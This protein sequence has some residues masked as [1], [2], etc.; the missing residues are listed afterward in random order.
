MYLPGAYGI[1][2]FSLLA[3]GVVGREPSDPLTLGRKFLFVVALLSHSASS[4]SRA[5]DKLPRP[6][7][8]RFFPPRGNL[9]SRAAIAN[10]VP[11]REYMAC[12]G[13]AR[14]PASYRH[15]VQVY[16]GVRTF[17]LTTWAW[18][19]TVVQKSESPGSFPGRLEKTDE[20]PTSGLPRKLTVRGTVH[21]SHGH[22][23]LMGR[24]CHAP[25]P[26]FSRKKKMRS[27]ALAF[28]SHGPRHGPPETWVA[29]SLTA[30]ETAHP[31]TPSA[32]I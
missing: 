14:Y 13:S 11:F 27:P 1:C 20:G 3:A 26:L 15:L 16:L 24:V 21:A 23:G 25:R 10:L 6:A 12:L 30:V 17:C 29:V 4:D 8:F 5:K 28:R 2:P 19:R 7:R 18:P 22:L 9:R 31:G 32:M